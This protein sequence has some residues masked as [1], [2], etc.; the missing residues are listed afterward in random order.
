MKTRGF[1][2]IEILVVMLVM[3]LLAG[4]V[5]PNIYRSVHSYQIHSQ[6]QGILAQLGEMSYRAYLTG[7]A[8]TLDSSSSDT[9]DSDESRFHLDIPPNWTLETVQPISFSFTGVCLSGGEI[10][11]IDPDGS[12]HLYILAPPKCRPEN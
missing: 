10:T 7:K 6:R 2:L 11:L 8:L 4:L 1:T 12:R 5:A 3:A 9:A